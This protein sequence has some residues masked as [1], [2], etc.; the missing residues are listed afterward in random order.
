MAGKRKRG[1][2]YSG[3]MKKKARTSGRKFTA[4]SQLSAGFRRALARNIE[5]KA[6][7]QTDVDGHEIFH[8]NFIVLNDSLLKTT[9]GISDQP[10][11]STSNRIG[12]SIDL[13][14]VKI[15]MMVELIE[16]YS[17][18]TFRGYTRR[19]TWTGEATRVAGRA[20]RRRRRG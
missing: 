10:A 9:Q 14:G 8:N 18:V 3:P 20:R 13:S 15:S 11:G 19:W 4:A 12:D 7:N 1:K 6:S 16:R 17:D 5:T 2:V